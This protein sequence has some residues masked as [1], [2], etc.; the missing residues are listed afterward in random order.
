MSHSLKI[1]KIALLLGVFLISASL[2]GCTAAP[3]RSNSLY[4]VTVGANDDDNV[5][6]RADY[7]SIQSAIDAAPDNGVIWR[8]KILPG[9]YRERVVIDRPFMRLIGSG[10][11]NTRI[12]FNRYSGQKISPLSDQ[13][14]GTS[15]SATV[16]VNGTDI[17]IENLTIENDFDFLTNERMSQQ[18]PARVSGT[19]AVAVRVGDYSDRVVFDHVNLLGYQDTLYV[20][21]GRSYFRGGEI[22][23]N[24]DFIFGDGNAY[25][26]KVNII[27]R[28]RAKETQ[29]SGFV[30]APS[31]LISQPF[32]LTFVDCR[33]T[34]EQGVPDNSVP[35][36]RPW[37]PTT[38][39]PDGRYANPFA[40]GKSVFINTYMDKHIAVNGWTSMGGTLKDGS[41]T[42]FGPIEDARFF[43]FNSTGPGAVVNLQRPQLTPEQASKYQLE[44][45]F[46]GWQPQ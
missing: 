4:D 19:Q 36:G 13:T 35:L 41:K 21:G 17:G 9:T 1:V 16:E 7:S 46:D 28:P 22:R 44:H 33:L 3:P 6:E 34:K 14:Y 31:T 45:I 5:N 10:A 2:T 15:G 11:E 27:S 39:F 40:I 32:G 12:V 23:G 24:V 42:Q 25:F 30:T 8:I 38:T 29:H 18:D 43:E 26:E 20:K 37:H